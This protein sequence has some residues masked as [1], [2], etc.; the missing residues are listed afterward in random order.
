MFKGISLLIW[1][2]EDPFATDAKDTSSDSQDPE[3]SD[4]AEEDEEEN[5][6]NGYK[7]YWM[8]KKRKEGQALSTVVSCSITSNAQMTLCKRPEINL[9]IEV[10]IQFTLTTLISVG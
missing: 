6:E 5:S 10:I 3:R 4:E 9:I 2:G 8:E 1:Q 7:E